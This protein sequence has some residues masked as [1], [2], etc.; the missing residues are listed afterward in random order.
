MQTVAEAS[1]R[2]LQHITRLG[3]ERVPLLDSLGRVLAEQVR[4]PMT[5]PAWANSAMDGYAV[6]AVD[7]DGVTPER[8]VRLRV[9]ETVA[10]GGFATQPVAAGSAIRIMTGAPLPE[11]ADTVVRVEDTDGGTE[12][13]VVRDA[14]SAEDVRG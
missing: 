9:L 6:R 14:R 8:P 12:T 2:I 3:V 13:V 10:A 5:L 7:I 11:A 4:A 1:G